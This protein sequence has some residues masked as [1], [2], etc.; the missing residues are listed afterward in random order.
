VDEVNLLDD[1]IVNSI[2][3]AAAQGHYTVR[4]GP[5]TNTYRARLTLIGSMN[6]E[7]GNLRPQILDR[8]GLRVVVG[9]LTDVEERREVARRVQ[10]YHTNHYDFAARLT[11]ATWQVLQEI[12]KARERLPRVDVTPAAEQ[13]A[14]DLV[15]HLHIQSLRAEI[16]LLQ[17]ARA[18][19]AADG[20]ETA[21]VTDV[22]AIAP[23]A[24]RLRY[25]PFIA[26]Y[27]EE[28]RNEDKAIQKAIDALQLTKKSA[29]D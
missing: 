9:G 24:L 11:D 27:V 17:A 12:N 26:K 14:L 10:A 28:R 7:E 21:E 25:S 20:R 8:F 5:M 18:R 2:L 6:P 19:A 3:D 4:R 15:D 16:V 22:T 29:G 1:S 13:A 23:M